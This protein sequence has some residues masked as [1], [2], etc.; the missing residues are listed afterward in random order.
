MKSVSVLILT[1]PNCEGFF[2]FVFLNYSKA[3][4]NLCP[5]LLGGGEEP[6]STAAALV[7]ALAGF[8]HLSALW[9]YD[10]MSVTA[11]APSGSCSA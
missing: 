5:K 1:S 8:L 4:L 11:P 6:I 7:A 9:R 3:I 10:Y 2:M